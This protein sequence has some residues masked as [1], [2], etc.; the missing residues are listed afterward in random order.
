MRFS[1]FYGIFLFFQ[2]IKEF[3][4]AIGFCTVRVINFYIIK[5]KSYAPRKLVCIRGPIMIIIVIFLFIIK[6]IR[7]IIIIVWRKYTKMTCRTYDIYMK[8]F[9]LDVK[10]L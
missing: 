9:K 3:C 10:Q 7:I 2:F 1:S 6:N 4:F 8:I 5:K